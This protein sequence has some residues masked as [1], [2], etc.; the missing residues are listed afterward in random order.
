MEHFPVRRI[1]NGLH[2]DGIPDG[3]AIVEIYGKLAR[4]LADLALH[5]NDLVFA[6]E[7]LDAI[8]IVPDEP[9]VIKEAL[10]RAAIVH[11]LKCFGN[12]ARFQLS[13]NAVYKAEPPEAMLAFNY[14]KALRNKH[15]VHDENSYAQSIPGAVLNDGSKNFKVEKIVSFSATAHTLEQANYGNLKQLVQK[16]LEWVNA[17]FDR[18]CRMLTEELEKK[19]YREL[20]A[21]KPL[22]YK[23]PSIEEL[24]HKRRAPN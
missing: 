21:M 9:R 8:N 11:C 12:G 6:D 3:V 5:K 1:G 10:W 2:V 18:V 22:T 19:P 15:L 23:V 7:T 4:R 20:A 14:F 17:E 16:A 13:A 24:F